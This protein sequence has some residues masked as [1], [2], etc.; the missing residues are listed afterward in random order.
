MCVCKCIHTYLCKYKYIHIF[1]PSLHTVKILLK[2]YQKHKGM[3]PT[4]KTFKIP[5]VLSQ[6]THK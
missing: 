5:K 1:K 3:S 2:M 4:Y 6:I